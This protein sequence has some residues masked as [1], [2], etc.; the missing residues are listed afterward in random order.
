MLQI[1]LKNP[2]NYCSEGLAAIGSS[3]ETMNLTRKIARELKNGSD[4]E[5]VVR[6]RLPGTDPK[7][8][9][10][11]L[12]MLVKG[13]EGTY[14]S[15]N[16]ATDGEWFERHLNSKLGK[17]SNDRRFAYLKN[18]ISLFPQGTLDEET[19]SRIQNMDINNI[20]NDDVTFMLNATRECNKTNASI[21]A[22]SA[23]R[24]LDNNLNSVTAEFAQELSESGV[25]TATAYA[26]ACY[27]L[28][29]SGKS[30]WSSGDN[31]ANEDP[32]TIGA[33][34]AAN[35]EKSKLISAYYHLKI[36]KEKLVNLLE[37]VILVPIALVFIV[38]SSPV[39]LYRDF[40]ERRGNK[41]QEAAQKDAAEVRQTAGSI[42][43]LAE[44]EE[45]EDEEDEEDEE[46]ED[47]EDEKE[48]DK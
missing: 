24:A 38:V 42:E 18:L 2:F 33:V 16:R 46:E 9:H 48:E 27:V 26:A 23:V 21:I 11:E 32:Y 29:R 15:L 45:E 19:L 31:V 37:I 39:L 36:T 22:R 28:N 3:I 41:A 6:E 12:Q 44:P 10:E 5:S 8:I 7:V 25:H 34:A 17:L 30:P 1:T 47:E 13:V 43:S 4:P 40:K 35:V 14:Q 20:S